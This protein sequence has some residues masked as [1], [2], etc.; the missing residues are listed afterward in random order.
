[1][2]QLRVVIAEVKHEDAMN[3]MWELEWQWLVTIADGRSTTLNLYTSKD[4]CSLKPV[5]QTG[6]WNNFFHSCFFL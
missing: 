4:D 2:A 5:H 6:A 1:M 3:S